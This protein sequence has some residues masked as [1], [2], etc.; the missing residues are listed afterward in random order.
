MCLYTNCSIAGS[1]APGNSL[2]LCWRRSRPR[3]CWSHDRNCPKTQLGY[4]NMLNIF[5]PFVCVSRKSDQ[6]TQKE[7]SNTRVLDKRTLH[8]VQRSLKTLSCVLL[9]AGTNLDVV[10]NSLKTSVISTFCC[11]QL[12]PRCQ[13][14]AHPPVSGQ[15][16]VTQRVFR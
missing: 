8:K 9:T 13:V 3:Y 15:V 6:L 12:P 16:V 11:C 5:M 2:G 10:S 14:C 1:V 7:V 4:T